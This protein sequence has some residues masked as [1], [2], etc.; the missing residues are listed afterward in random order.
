MN[1]YHITNARAF[2][3]SGF[4]VETILDVG[5]I[6]HGGLVTTCGDLNQYCFRQWLVAGPILTYHQKGLAFIHFRVISHG[7]L[8]ISLLDI[9][10]KVTNWGLQLYIPMR[11]RYD[12]K[13]NDNSL[14]ECKTAV[15]PVC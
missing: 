3:I 10:W 8:K 15:T 5:T 4:V 11:S 6:T 9:S 13:H 2:T 7:M 12:T 14:A 1:S